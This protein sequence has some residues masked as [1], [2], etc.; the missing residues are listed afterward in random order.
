MG[1]GA[2]LERPVHEKPNDY[3]AI[4]WQRTN[5]LGLGASRLARGRHL[6]FVARAAVPQC[7]LVFGN[8]HRPVEESAGRRPDPVG[9][10]PHAE[11]DLACRFA[12]ST[13]PTAARRRNWAVPAGTRRGITSRAPSRSACPK[14]D[15]GKGST[16][17]SARSRA[18]TTAWFTTIRSAASLAATHWAIAQPGLRHRSRAGLPHGP[19][20]HWGL[21]YG[22]SVRRGRLE[23]PRQFRHRQDPSAARLEVGAV[24]QGLEELAGHRPVGVHGP[25]QVDSRASD[26]GTA[27]LALPSGL[28]GLSGAHHRRF[29]LH[30]L[31]RDDPCHGVHEAGVRR[32]LVEQ[33]ARDRSGRCT[34]WSPGFS[35]IRVCRPSRTARWTTRSATAITTMPR[36]AAG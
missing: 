10:E 14:A 25:S 16:S 20:A 1:A 13:G 18:T 22:D 8:V 30:A 11:K 32:Q 19:V 23:C 17:A 5:S 7:S 6:Q 27:L 9:T 24:S 28:R 12:S 35:S 31:A 33:R 34:R 15:C 4:I 29:R 2:S 3:P 36:K 26:R 21:R